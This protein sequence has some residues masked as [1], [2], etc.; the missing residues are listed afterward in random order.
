MS[1]SKANLVEELELHSERLDDIVHSTMPL[2]EILDRDGDCSFAFTVWTASRVYF[3]TTSECFYS[4]S[5]VPRNP[6]EEECGVFY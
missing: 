1:T 6:S 2:D 3:P 4:I 5:S